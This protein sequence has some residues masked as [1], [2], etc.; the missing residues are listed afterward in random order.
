MASREEILADFQACTGVDDVEVAICQLEAADWVLV[1]AV[2]K[3]MSS[4]AAASAAS[5]PVAAATAPT[6]AEPALPPTSAATAAA[7]SDSRST[8]RWGAPPPPPDLPP[9]AAQV[10]PSS[11]ASFADPSSMFSAA[12]AFSGIPGGFG[13]A[14]GSIAIADDLFAGP[15]TSSGRT[16]MLDFYISHNDRTIHLKVPDNEDVKT[17]KSLIQGETGFSPCQQTLRGF[18]RGFAPDHRPQSDHRRLSDM[19]LPKENFLQL[20]TPEVDEAGSASTSNGESG[21]AEE[22]AVDFR[23]NITD[24]ST[25]R[26]YNLNFRPTHSVLNVKL[27]V[28]SV[29]NIAVS[30]QAW[31]GWPENVNDDLSL[32]QLGIPT[33]H[34]LYVN[35]KE[36]VNMPIVIDDDDDD[37]ETTPPVAAGAAAA[38]AAPS[39]SSGS[40]AR[41]P[42]RRT[43]SGSGSGGDVVVMDSDDEFEDANDDVMDDE[44][45]FGTGAGGASGSDH[46]GPRLQPLIPDDYGDEAMA[47]IKFSEEFSGRFGNPSPH[48]F[49]GS[50]DD[51]IRESCQQPAKERKMLAIYLHHDHSVLTNVFC[52]QAL[53]ADSVVSFLSANFVT[54]GWDLTLSSNKRRALDMVTKHFGS[55]AAATI[56]NTGLEKMP[57]LALVYKLR[58]TM[59]IVQVISGSSTL[60]ELMSQLLSAQ[61]TYASQL[62]VE[63]REEGEREARN[64]VKA[65]QDL[66]FEMAQL[67]DREKEE[68]K[69][70]EAEERLEQAKIE[71]AVKRSEEEAKERE[72]REKEARR[73]KVAKRLPKEPKEGA[74][75]VARLRF[76]IVGGDKTESRTLER[77]FLASDSL[78]TVFDFLTVEGLES[79]EDYKVISSWPRRDLTTLEDFS[80]SLE[81]L[82]LFPQET[83]TLEEK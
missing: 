83:L 28:S 7:G 64:A 50:L 77:R 23:L 12:A 15:S 49:P 76:R 3:A 79:P 19:N 42:V 81:A 18:Q 16:R 11:A 68:V 9:E 58:G 35:K 34:N 39:T 63:V 5:P 56:K 20:L 33:Q 26:T 59:E 65:E 14:G 22:S 30:K 55:V 8:S 6:P 80:Q 70:R 48:F 53:C 1:D 36:N 61:D 73:Q 24:E 78:Q 43:N 75:K 21:V 60:D 82:K 13:G 47:G 46:R 37:S 52:T 57:L 41:P 67:A 62:T 32:A 40:S 74:D 72:G 27:D 38:A 71:E 45:I 29:T 54:F 69:R 10:L 44:D 66:A 31:R 4:T 25:G 17:L 2:N 51:A